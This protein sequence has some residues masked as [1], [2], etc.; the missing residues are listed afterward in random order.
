MSVA[1]AAQTVE[2]RVREVDVVAQPP[3]RKGWADV[4]T[5]LE[6]FDR[7]G[8]VSLIGD[9]YG[10]NAA[11]RRFLHSR[12]APSSDSI[13]EYH[14]L[15]ADAI[16]PDPLSSRQISV[17][18]AGAVIVEYKRS[19]GDAAGTIDLMLTFVEAGTEQSADLGYGDDAYFSAL[20]NKLDAIVKAF[21]ELPASV[22]ATTVARLTRIRNRA[23]DIGWGYGDFVAD[24]VRTLEK[25]AARP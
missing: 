13:E 17:R 11:N 22:Q 24:V 25:R 6:S 16:Y 14:R 15:V 5:R 3:K 12:L 2:D 20:E 7:K 9:L 21:K 10:A 1:A 8:L 23:K 4:K 19:T 18:D